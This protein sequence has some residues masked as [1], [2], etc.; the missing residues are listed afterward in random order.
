MDPAIQNRIDRLVQE[1]DERIK[2]S[3]SLAMQTHWLA[4]GLMAAAIGCSVLAGIAGIA[5]FLPK[6][7]IGVIAF[8]PSAVAVAALNFKP[9]GRSSWHYR[10]SDA[11][12]A[13]RS[14]LLYQ[15]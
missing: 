13:L 10:K 8:V 6:P 11:L 12:Y 4:I 9:Q 14:R 2:V 3:D 1:L 5:G 15:L 7:A